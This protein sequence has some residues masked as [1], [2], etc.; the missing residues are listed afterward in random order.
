VM[1]VSGAG[2]K[3]YFHQNHLYSV[4]AMTDSTGAVVER[5]RYDAYGKRTVTNAG[6]TPIA[7]STIGQAHG[8]T[9]CYLD[10][11]TG[12]Y[13]VRT[14]MYH[15]SMGRFISRD[16]AGYIEG[17]GLYSGY[18]VPNGVDPYGQWNPF[19]IAGAVIGGVVGAVGG[20]IGGA[21]TGGLTGALT[22]AV[23]GLVGGAVTGGLIGSGMPPA[24]AAAIGGAIGGFINTTLQ[25]IANHGASKL[26]SVEFAINAAVST[27]IGA[28]AG[29]AGGWASDFVPSGT[30][31]SVFSWNLRANVTL[32]FTDV[33]VEGF[34][35]TVGNATTTYIQ[36]GPQSMINSGT[37]IIE[38][39]T[40]QWQEE[41]RACETCE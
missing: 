3:H 34:V 1:M 11:E 20:A 17:L 38:E 41:S 36:T 22:G 28:G 35:Q 32:T 37:R 13:Y 4:A 9:G 33:V 21:I 31:V 8:F 27:A 29:L 39:R 15:P 6:G 12:L 23:S 30:I 16:L 18:F 19:A 40:Q 7:T 26:C 5:Y 2:T 10:G 25:T 14:R 24:A